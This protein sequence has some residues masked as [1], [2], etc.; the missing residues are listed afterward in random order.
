MSITLDEI[1]AEA[2]KAREPVSET[3]ATAVEIA[4]ELK[5]AHVTARRLLAKWVEAGTW[6]IVPVIRYT[7]AGYARRW[8]GY[9][10][11]AKAPVKSK[12]K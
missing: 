8:P 4:A 2:R 9:R 5:I 10:P 6:E 12:R 1:L 3:A 7:S 11:V